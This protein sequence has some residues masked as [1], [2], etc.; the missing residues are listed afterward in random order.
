M[1]RIVAVVVAAG[2]VAAGCGGGGT[3]ATSAPST[4]RPSPTPQ[5]VFV[6]Q[7]DLLSSNEVPPIADAE[8]S[9]SGTSTV[10]LTVTRDATGTITAAT[11]KFE[12]GVKGC[13]STSAVILAHIHQAAA[14]VNGGVKVDS[15]LKADSPT[16]VQGGAASFTKDNLKVDPQLASDI[17]AGP[18]GFYFNIH[19]VV[20]PGGVVRAQLKLKA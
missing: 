10:T 4:A 11:A 20:H 18:A 15:G 16:P 7:Q 6:F 8:Q 19:T 13:P 14:G 2:L 5:T 17:V 9:C 12:F 3:A 1:T